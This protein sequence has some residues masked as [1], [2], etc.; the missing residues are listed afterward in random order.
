MNFNNNKIRKVIN[1]RRTQMCFD[2]VCAGSTTN[3]S[4]AIVT[5]V[6]GIPKCILGSVLSIMSLYN[7]VKSWKM[8]RENID[9]AMDGTLWIGNHI[10]CLIS[11]WMMALLKTTRMRNLVD[12]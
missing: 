3:L 1:H 5:R 10:F 2:T 4:L 7:L 6:N 12:R 11:I 9:N 8:F